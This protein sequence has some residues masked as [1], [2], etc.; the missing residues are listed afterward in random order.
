MIG[1]PIDHSLSPRI[2]RAFAEQ[3]GQTIDYQALRVDI[4]RFAASL[5]ALREQGLCGAS[6][7]LPFKHE[8]WAICDRRSGRAERAG[9]VNTISF[10]DHGTIVGD[11]TDGIG[12]LRDLRDN[13]NIALNDR[14]IL[15]LG[16]GGAVAGIVEPLL[17]EQPADLVI[18]NRSLDKAEAIARRFADCARIRT[19]AYTEL[20]GRQFPLVINGTSLSLHDQL[21]PLPDGVMQAQGF[22]Y[23]MMYQREPTCFMRWAL[24]Q[25]A[26]GCADGLGMLVE[27]AAEAFAIWRG[28]RPETGP[29]LE[30]LRA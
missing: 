22:A 27:Q 7:T 17:D 16:A 30:Q 29:V 19:V 9:A 26:A 11:N 5:R 21:P 23:D 4:D 3:T 10:A 25:G 28:V 20:K 14:D 6:I 18:A 15:I 12:L 13:L 8:A 24:A 2:H 1:N